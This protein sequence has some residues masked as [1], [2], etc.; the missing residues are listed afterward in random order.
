MNTSD[1][2]VTV[3]G[4]GSIGT[5]VSYTLMNRRSASKIA[6]VNRSSEK[7]AIKAFDMS[8]CIPW[9]GNVSLA[10]GPIEESAGSQVVIITVGTLPK[11]DGSRMDVLQGNIDIYS[12]LIP[13][14]ARLS[15][16]AVFLTVTNPVDIMA[17]AA[18]KYS[19][20]PSQRILGS[21]T[22]LDT[23]RFRSFIAEAVD[24][25]PDRV[26]AMI[27]GEH[28]ES[29]VPV[30]SRAKV[31]DTALELYVKD[32]GIMWNGKTMDDIME[33][34]RR[35]GWAI[36]EGNEH[37]TYAI[38]F[39]AAMITEAILQER[40]DYLPVSFNQKDTYG[41][42]DLFMSLPVRLARNGCGEVEQLNL[43]DDEKLKLKK[44]SEI[45]Y[46]HISTIRF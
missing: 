35:A 8:H 32:H 43:N 26:D 23:L 29:M 24:V 4:A 16:E 33:K 5:L 40:Q 42:E 38:A 7:A 41:G 2:K 21:G 34:T 46:Q 37:S 9:L 6:L 20:F 1:G 31:D 25:T 15:P 14:L 44:S 11:K 39:S 45:L 18:E 12:E 3:V 36:R 13:R 10:G 17:L 22:L 28:G 27:V 19:G 30:W